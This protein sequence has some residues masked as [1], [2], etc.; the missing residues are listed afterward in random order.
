MSDRCA[1]RHGARRRRDRRVARRLKR[2]VRPARLRAIGHVA[3]GGGHRR[4][5]RAGRH[6]PRRRVVQATGGPP[7]PSGPPGDGP[8]RHRPV[9]PAR[10]RVPWTHPRNRGSGCGACATGSATSSHTAPAAGSAPRIATTS[11]TRVRT[12]SARLAHTA[13]TSHPRSKTRSASATV[14]S[15]PQTSTAAASARHRK[16][17]RPASGWSSS[18]CSR[19]SSAKCASRITSPKRPQ[20]W[21]PGSH[22]DCSH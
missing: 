19:R 4:G 12:R 5:G 3:A 21:S 9:G 16:S 13:R 8:A 15:L 18:R 17:P 22:S 7:Q 6:R 14:R 2:A 11:S 1:R 10:D 20:A